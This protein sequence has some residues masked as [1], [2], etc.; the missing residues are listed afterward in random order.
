MLFVSLKVYRA[1]AALTTARTYLSLTVRFERRSIKIRLPPNA[2]I[3]F[4]SCARIPRLRMRSSKEL[5]KPKSDGQHRQQNHAKN[6]GA[7][8]EAN[9]RAHG[10]F[11]WL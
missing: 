5:P 3:Y 2:S 7:P 4:V 11:A 9:G 1:G 8:H 10:T 6:N